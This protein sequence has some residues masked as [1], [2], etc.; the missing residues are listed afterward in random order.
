M[1]KHCWL[2]YIHHTL[3]KIEIASVL[4]IVGNCVH[5][6]VQYS[7]KV[8]QKWGT[9]GVVDIWP[10]FSMVYRP[11]ARKVDGAHPKSSKHPICQVFYR[12]RSSKM[13]TIHYHPFEQMVNFNWLFT[14]T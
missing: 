5:E 9:F 6:P 1:Q 11:A 4:G 13:R 14:K 3:W 12:W 7:G 2:Y 8:H 10:D